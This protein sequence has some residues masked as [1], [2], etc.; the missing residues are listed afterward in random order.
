[1]SAESDHSPC[2]PDL[3]RADTGDFAAAWGGIASLQLGLPVVWTQAATRGF[4]LADVVRWMATRPAEVVG[5]ARK[6][7]IAVGYDADLVAF[8]PDAAFVVDAGRL[9]HRH[10]VTPY[11]GRALL[12]KV[13]TTWLRGSV[14][15]GVTPRGRLLSRG[16]A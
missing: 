8:E 12:G 1:M 9:R 5:L 2:T 6:G 10:P 15:D 16:A 7:R 13:R 14:V 11:H 3:K 4:T